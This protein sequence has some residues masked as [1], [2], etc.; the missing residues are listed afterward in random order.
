MLKFT[1]LLYTTAMWTQSTE[2]RKYQE[3]SLENRLVHHATGQEL[4]P[5]AV[6]D[7][8]TELEQFA[9][10]HASLPVS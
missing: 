8:A 7:D 6:A 1:V 10:E 2:V 4:E 5:K 9:L 3:T